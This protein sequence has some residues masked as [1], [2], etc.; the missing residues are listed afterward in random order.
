MEHDNAMFYLS[1]C[2]EG[3]AFEY[4]IC[5]DTAKQ[6]WESLILTYDTQEENI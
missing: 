4:V 5:A 2:F 1:M 3:D 6:A